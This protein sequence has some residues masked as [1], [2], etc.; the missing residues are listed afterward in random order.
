MS[1]AQLVA[2]I[3]EHWKEMSTDV[4]EDFIRKTSRFS[5]GDLYRIWD[6]MLEEVHYP[7][8][9]EDIH[10]I[11]E[12]LMIK[13]MLKERPKKCETCGGARWIQVVCTDRDGFPYPAVKPCS[14]CAPKPKPKDEEKLPF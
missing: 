6:R 10:R 8:K 9:I 7:P 11:S 12:D 1:P 14:C 3:E 5:P 4:K 2:R 13:P